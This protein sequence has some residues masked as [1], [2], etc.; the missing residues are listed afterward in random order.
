M[1]GGVGF[2]YAPREERRR[3]A[4]RRPQPN[5]SPRAGKRAFLASRLGAVALLL[6]QVAAG[7]AVLAS[8]HWL[9]DVQVLP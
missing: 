8:L 4:V 3:L 7:V 6:A 2:D 1:S 5:L 9:L